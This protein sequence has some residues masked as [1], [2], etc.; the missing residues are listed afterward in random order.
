MSSV[1]GISSIT[2]LTGKLVKGD[3]EKDSVESFSNMLSNAIKQADD[4]YVTSQNDTKALLSG[5]VDN[6]AQVMVNSTKAE[7]SLNM[8]IQVRNQIVNT[9]NEIMRMQV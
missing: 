6:I 8:V 1:S 9:Y 4:L 2:G 3:E 7:L 5:E